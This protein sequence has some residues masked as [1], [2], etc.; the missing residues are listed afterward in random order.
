MAT[1]GV[2]ADQVELALTPF[3]LGE[4]YAFSA[5]YIFVAYVLP[6]L[7]EPV[8]IFGEQTSTEP[9]VDP[10]TPWSSP[11]V[12]TVAFAM[13]VNPLEVPCDTPPDGIALST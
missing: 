4:I 7:L 11:R 9:V 10:K 5:L 2:R 12:K 13:P 6:K 1:D 3:A 8:A